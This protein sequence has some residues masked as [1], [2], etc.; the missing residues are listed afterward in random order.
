M[1]VL[2]GRGLLCCCRPWSTF[3]TRTGLFFSSFFFVGELEG[4]S[5]GGSFYSECSAG[6]NV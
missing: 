1:V 5:S 2:G 3:N 4:P 6:T